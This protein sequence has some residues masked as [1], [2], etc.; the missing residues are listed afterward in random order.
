MGGI[1][2]G[3]GGGFPG[4]AGRGGSGGSQ[5]AG[6]SGTADKETETIVGKHKGKN[7]HEPAAK[8]KKV[9]R[10]SICSEDHFTNQ[11]PQLHG[12]KPS[13]T[14]C[15]LAGDGLGFFHI[16]VDGAKPT[17]ARDHVSAT[18]LVTILEGDVSVELL[19]SELARILPVK[20]D[21]EVH[22]HG[23]KAFVVP[24]PC[25]VELDRMVAIGSII[26]KHKE[27]VL[28][29]EE[30]NTEIKPTRKL[31]QVWVRVFGVMRSDPSSH[32]GQ[33]GP[34]LGLLKR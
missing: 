1:F 24:F 27:G 10:C 11:C 2:G 8:K 7:L 5:V 19:K 15:G 17:I 12:P 26:T 22:E 25:K 33:L 4:F 9:L 28:L 31:E 14:F 6:G 30:Y 18:A 29:F 21:W 16:P 32:C 3:G 13:A 23:D 34:Y 20:W